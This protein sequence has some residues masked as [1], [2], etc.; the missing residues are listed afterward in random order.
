MEQHVWSLKVASLLSVDHWCF[1]SKPGD[2]LAGGKSPLAIRVSHQLARSHHACEVVM[3]RNWLVCG[4]R[5]FLKRVFSS[6]EVFSGD[7][8]IA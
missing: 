4:F 5:F 6:V 2:R 7:A 1:P 3:C 8:L